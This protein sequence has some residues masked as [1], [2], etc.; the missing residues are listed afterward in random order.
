MNLSENVSSGGW[1][2][3]PETESEPR[4]QAP[5]KSTDAPPNSPTSGKPRHLSE[6]DRLREA[7]G[8]GQERAEGSA[9]GEAAQPA[10]AHEAAPEEAAQ[11]PD[12]SEQAEPLTIKRLAEK[13]E[14]EPSALYRDLQISLGDGETVGLQALKDVYDNRQT[15]ER[16]SEEKTA[17][18]ERREAEI[19]SQLQELRV[20]HEAGLP[21]AAR[22]EA[23]KVLRG[24]LQ[25][26]TEWFL[27]LA[28]EL[29]D[30]A[31]LEGFKQ[32]AVEAMQKV[33]IR[34]ADMQ[35]VMSHHGAGLLMRQLLKLERENSDLK[36]RNRP[37]P[38]RASKPNAVPSSQ[39]YA[40]KRNAQ[41]KTTPTPR[42]KVS[43]A[44]GRN[45]KN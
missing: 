18:Q 44:L 36:Q 39:Q 14:M 6:R 43:A 35:Q 16:V 17:D 11:D 21:P 15:A 45:R 30:P 20:M 25:K 13:L 23:Q 28:P 7:L 5:E 10:E 38:P 12:T 8:G 4:S 37:K 34:R 42:G 3:K 9:Q 27:T 24:R 33:G 19:I 31:T 40:G 22:A 26:E 32:D 1:Q 41:A 29:R 2:G